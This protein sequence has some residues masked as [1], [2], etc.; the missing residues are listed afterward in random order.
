M[1][2]VQIYLKCNSQMTVTCVSIFAYVILTYRLF[3]KDCGLCCAL[4]RGWEL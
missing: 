4:L 1:I 2:I 3:M